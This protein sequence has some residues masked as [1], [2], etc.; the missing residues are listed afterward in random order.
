MIKEYPMLK[1][2]LG[3]IAVVSLAGCTESSKTVPQK[4]TYPSVSEIP[5]VPSYADGEF[6]ISAEA[7]CWI[8]IESDAKWNNLGGDYAQRQ[9]ATEIQL[10]IRQVLIEKG[11]TVENFENQYLT[12]QKRLSVNRIILCKS[13]EIKKI[14]VQEGVC[15]DMKLTLV[16]MDNADQNRVTDC[17]IWGRSV[18]HTGERKDWNLI[19]QDCVANLC[20]V[21]EFKTAIEL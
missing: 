9:F 2:V 5:P 20:K 16:V 14:R 4:I 19:Y 21:R 11:F 1:I 15:Y 17:E 7:V 6:S 18:V 13:F 3:F 8:G 12:R 10:L